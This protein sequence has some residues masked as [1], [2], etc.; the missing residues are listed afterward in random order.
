MKT[1]IETGYSNKPYKNITSGQIASP[2]IFI[3]GG[4]INAISSPKENSWFPVDY[5]FLDWFMHDWF[6]KF[7]SA[8]SGGENFISN[9]Q[10]SQNAITITTGNRNKEGVIT[11]TQNVKG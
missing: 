5:F 8:G 1:N 11:I 2:A 10:V 6:P 9:T 3:D 7:I 4:Y